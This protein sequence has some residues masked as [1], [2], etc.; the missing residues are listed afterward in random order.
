MKSKSLPIS[1]LAIF[2]GIVFVAL[3]PEMQAQEHQKNTLTQLQQA[4]INP[5]T[6]TVDVK[7]VQNAYKQAAL[8]NNRGEILNWEAKGPVNVGGSVHAIVIDQQDGS[9]RTLIAGAKAGGLWKSTNGGTNWS[10]INYDYNLFVTCMVQTT[11][12]IIYIGTGGEFTGTGLYKLTNN[13]I[14]AIN[15]SEF[16]SINDLACDG[17]NLY[18]AT[19]EGLKYY[20]G[21]S[22]SD[23]H[24]N[25][26][27][28]SGSVY[29]V[30][31]NEGGKIITSIQNSCYISNS[32]KDGFINFST[33]EANKLPSANTIGS[34]SITFDASNNDIFYACAAKK[35]GKLYA[36]YMSQ[37]AG[38]TWEIILQGGGSIDPFVYNTTI[39]GL[40]HNKIF[41]IQNMTACNA[42][43]ISSHD[44]WFGFRLKTETSGFFDFGTNA[45]TNS[46]TDCKSPF[47]L[48]SIVHDMVFDAN[49]SA[50]LATEGGVYFTSHILPI[51]GVISF[52]KLN[53]TLNNTLVNHV[54]VD[55]D[56]NPVCGT[57]GTSV[58]MLNKNNNHE[59]L[60]N[61]IWAISDAS[62]SYT[63]E[64]KSDFNFSSIIMQDF[65]FNTSTINDK[66]A[67]R[68]SYDN[69]F[70]FDNL[71]NGTSG[72]NTPSGIVYDVLHWETFNA[73]YTPDTTLFYAYNETDSTV[74][75]HYNN[76]EPGNIVWGYSKLNKYPIPFELTT[77]L[78][79]GDIVSIPD[80]VQT[81][82]FL[83]IGKNVYMSNGLL[84]FSASPKWDKLATVPSADINVSCL[85]V[86]ANCE[87]LYFGT[88]NG[89]V[90][91]ILNIEIYYTNTDTTQT[92]QAVEIA[93]FQGQVVTSICVNNQNKNNVVVTLGNYGFNDYIFVSEN[94]TS[95]NPTFTSIQNN[96][97]KMPIY[98]SLMLKNTNGN[99]VIGTDLGIFTLD[100]NSTDWTQ[101]PTVKNVIVKKLTQQSLE[102]V[103][104]C[105]PI[106]NPDPSSSEMFI[107]KYYSPSTNNGVL[108]AGTYGKGI[109]KSNKYQTDPVAIPGELTVH[110]AEAVKFYP[111]PVSSTA[112]LEIN[113]DVA[114]M[115][116]IHVF[117]IQGR[118]LHQQIINL[119][120]GSNIHEMN[121]SNFNAGV[122]IVKVIYG[123]NSKAVKVIKSL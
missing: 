43:F 73:T 77:Q 74:S 71:T 95:N 40:T 18:L 44:L 57:D 85:A 121:F 62:Y 76:W 51:N 72:V 96:L 16:E 60:S 97:P 84:D 120:A 102:R 25:G 87:D 23:C 105:V 6:G 47:Y 109:Y 41:S 12:N 119:Q 108:Y 70:S 49:G 66:F 10:L 29:E 88:A 64:G 118:C 107:H 52:T 115:A 98:T 78:Q 31:V 2:L 91:R 1:L 27:V 106:R 83:A 4:R 79:H 9:N 101:D 14:E 63:F 100:A 36:L 122:Y 33:G 81:R 113:A 19:N 99:L 75:T 30:Q 48:H 59:T 58:V 92:F 56:G 24:A 123:K 5:S 50:Y 15:G 22:F 53:T 34:L 65:V 90:Y 8:L 13:T 7:D 110:V 42:L 89:K 67:I 103:G 11:D 55:G 46:S 35:D 37:N 104:V 82:T 111:N 17:N 117:D 116:T 93:N 68:R 3:T 21:T 94:A 112:N 20:D 86:S 38:N 45:V 39:Y 32:D 54:C 114:Q 61:P 26:E 69:G 28:L 80:R